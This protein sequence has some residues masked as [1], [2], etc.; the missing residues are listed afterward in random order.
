M[1]LCFNVWWL[2]R[3]AGGTAEPDRCQLKR[4]GDAIIDEDVNDANSM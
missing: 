2:D 4:P 1:A 3:K